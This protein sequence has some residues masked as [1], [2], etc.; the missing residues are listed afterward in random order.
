MSNLKFVVD[1]APFRDLVSFAKVGLGAGTGKD[2]ARQVVRFDV[3]GSNLAL[4]ASD[5][6]LTAWGGMPVQAEASTKGSF[7]VMG[8][9]LTGLVSQ[10]T[11]AEQYEFIV[12]AENV[13]IR[14]GAGFTVNFERYD[15][16]LLAATVAAQ[17][18]ARNLAPPPP[19]AEIPR[20]LAVESFAVAAGAASRSSGKVELSHVELREQH[21]LAS[22]SRRICAVYSDR[23]H[24]TSRLKVPVAVVDRVVG[25][26]KSL[27]KAAGVT[28]C[29]SAGYYFLAAPNRVLAFRKTAN[30]FPA[31]E[32]V[33]REQFDVDVLILNREATLRALDDVA[34]GLA[35]DEV[36]IGFRAEGN[37]ATLTSENSIGRASTR[38]LSVDR[39]GD[40]GPVDF[41]ISIDH[42]RTILGVMGAE[43]VRLEAVDANDVVRVIDEDGDRRIA[44]LLPYRRAVQAQAPEAEGTEAAPEGEAAGGEEHESGVQL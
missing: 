3:E 37:T 19:E 20:A 36:K 10:I 40:T 7:A 33:L 24:R 41:P 39:G 35:G 18:E 11:A 31:V 26:L 5:G 14:A 6:D 1:A 9:R 23:F 16:D 42:L 38:R 17:D 32:K 44:A 12:D 43:L 27:D 28:P 13:E 22:D 8:K 2:L 30:D 25:A 4:V 29:E 21:L 34:L 15:P